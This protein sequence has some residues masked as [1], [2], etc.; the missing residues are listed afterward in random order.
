MKETI[1]SN[2]L[3]YVA[4]LAAVAVF[5]A[6]TAKGAHA[7]G[8]QTLK[9]KHLHYTPGPIMV[10]FHVF[11]QDA[12]SGQVYGIRGIVRGANDSE[13]G[14]ILVQEHV[15]PWLEA[16]KIQAVID[17][18]RATRSSGCAATPRAPTGSRSSRVSPGRLTSSI[19][20]KRRGKTAQSREPK[21]AFT[22]ESRV[23]Y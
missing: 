16:R 5:I 18:G 6:S 1:K 20:S 2:L 12:R 13:D 11:V 17:G 22:T 21:I 19:S 7:G 23:S 14:R 15:Q 9:E 10:N 8:M 3:L 4:F